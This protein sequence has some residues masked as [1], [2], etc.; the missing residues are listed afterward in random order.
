MEFNDN[1]I[2]I[3]GHNGST[4]DPFRPGHYYMFFGGYEDYK[5]FNGT[6]VTEDEVEMA[7]NHET[8]HCLLDSI[9]EDAGALDNVWYMYTEPIP[10]LVGCSEFGIGY[11]P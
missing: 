11:Q 8:L 4:E 9:G 7:I 6:I 2:E 3:I 10:I 5:E 1:I